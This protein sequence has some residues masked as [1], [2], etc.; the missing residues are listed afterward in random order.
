MPNFN[1]KNFVKKVSLVF[2]SI[3][4]EV[5]WIMVD[6]I[7][8]MSFFWLTVSSVTAFIGKNLTREIVISYV[9]GIAIC[10]ALASVLFSYAKFVKMMRN[11][12]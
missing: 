8:I 12:K 3:I 10:L 7:L 9:S 4:S 5:A 6:Y 2:L 11:K 1:F